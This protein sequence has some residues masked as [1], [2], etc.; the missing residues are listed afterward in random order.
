MQFVV[1][2]FSLELQLEVNA[3]IAEC[4]LLSTTSTQHAAYSCYH[5]MLKRIVQYLTCG[6]VRNSAVL[7]LDVPFQLISGSKPV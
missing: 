2:A 3:A 1:Y 6:C 7:K 5:P 4:C